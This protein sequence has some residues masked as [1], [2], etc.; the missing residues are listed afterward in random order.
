MAGIIDV[1]GERD[2]E[3]YANEKSEFMEDI[4]TGLTKPCKQIQSKYFY[5]E[6]GS[7]LFNQIT[8]HPDY[9]LTRCEIEILTTYKH[10][11]AS[12]INSESFNLVELGPGEGVKTRILIEEF[13]QEELDFTYL[14]I[15]ISKRYLKHLTHE[16]RSQLGFFRLTPIHSDYFRGLEWLRENSERKNLVLFLGSSIGNFNQEETK[17]FLCH[18]CH[19]LNKG[20]YI[21]L[22]F[23][24]RK[25]VDL[26]MHAY[27]DCD[28]I[29][30][31]FNLNLLQRV[32]RELG[33]DFD[34]NKFRH[35]ATYNVYSGAMESYLLSLEQQLVTIDAVNKSFVFDAIEPIHVEY[36]HKFHVSQIE[37]LAHATGFEIIQNFMDAKG[38]FIDT[39]WCV[40]K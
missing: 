22:G 16:F 25:D 14:P 29:T 26:L 8:R 17:E 5:D 19:S 28:G 4:V 31:E 37:E 20:D 9:Y 34:L 6:Y 24:L 1:L 18:L 36:S 2:L 13:L 32:N 23:D 15:D 39:L 30:R 10:Q 35:Y 40:D 3:E 33:G 11:I 12:L 27:N 38:F 21:L 7:E